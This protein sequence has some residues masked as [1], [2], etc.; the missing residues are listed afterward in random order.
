MNRIHLFGKSATPQTPPAVQVD[1]ARWTHADRQRVPHALFA[2]LHYE[3]NYSYPLLVWLHGPNDDERQLQRIMPMLSMR[4]Y[5]AIGARGN[6]PSGNDRAGNACAGNA[7]AGFGWDDSP[8]A[9][10]TAE[11]Q[12]FEVIEI[13]RTRFNIAAHRIFL[14]GLENG[15][16]MA[17]RIAAQSPQQF[18]GVLSIGGSF[19]RTGQPLSRLTDLRFVPLF[20]AQGRDSERYPEDQLCA[21]L[22]L[23]H[24]AGLNITLRQYPCGDELNTQMLQDMDAWLMEIVTGQAT[25][26][27]PPPVPT[28]DWN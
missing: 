9:L 3:R 11:Q 21:D 25:R 13:A 18:A 28:N 12:I 8:E 7:C 6:A 15:G 4:N 1:L 5:V 17:Y 23:M 10:P 20:I 14:A 16:T 24:S 19:P 26:P 27:Q 2:P 22:R